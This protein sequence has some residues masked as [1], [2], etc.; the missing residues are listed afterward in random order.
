MKK[1]PTIFVFLIGSVWFLLSFACL[2]KKPTETSDTERRA[3]AQFPAITKESVLEG[4]FAT[5]FEDYATDQF[6]LR[7]QFRTLKAMW[8]YYGYLQSDNNGI[9]IMDGHAGKIEYPLKESSIK[10]ACEK[11]TYLYNKYIKDNNCKVYASVVPDKG[12]FMAE[13][14]GVLS[15]DYEKLFSM[16]KEGLPFA[17]YIP[18]EDSLELSDYYKTDTHWRQEDI[19]D[20][21]KKIADAM[22]ITSRI[23]WDFTKVETDE[24]FYGVY[25]GQAAL[26]LKSDTLNYLTNPVIEGALVHHADTGA[27][28]AV[29]DKDK[30]ASKDSYEMFLSGAAPILTIENS[31]A[32]TDK[33]LVIF[34]DSFGSSITPLLIEAYSKITLVDTRYIHSDLVGNY[35]NFEN[36]DVL[37]LYST[38]VLNNSTVLK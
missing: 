29:Y 37:F 2:I 30:L 15:L 19:V 3:L 8:Q 31:V 6:P 16:V 23:S 28:T 18:I 33:E 10:N 13:E 36:A 11:F 14:A 22:G 27:T 5:E 26:P 24:P 17:T 32:K 25:Y 9:Y 35:V 1:K 12:Y 4:K 38:L 20:V 21:A 7:N 34:R